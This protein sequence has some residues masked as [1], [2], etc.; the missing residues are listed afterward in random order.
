MI[1]INGEKILMKLCNWC[2]DYGRYPVEGCWRPDDEVGCLDAEGK[3]ICDA[4]KKAYEE[5]RAEQKRR[6]KKT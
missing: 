1:A 3:W 5:G 2:K 4:C 6:A